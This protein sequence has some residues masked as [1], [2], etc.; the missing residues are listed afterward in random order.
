MNFIVQLSKVGQSSKIE[1]KGNRKTS[2]A[3]RLG[4]CKSSLFISNIY[5]AAISYCPI[6]F[7]SWLLVIIHITNKYSFFSPY[8]QIKHKSL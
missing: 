2:G 5:L 7:D 4:V 3:T 6:V 1:Q 8:S